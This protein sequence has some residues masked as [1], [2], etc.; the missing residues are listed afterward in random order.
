MNKAYKNRL[1]AQLA[2]IDANISKIHKAG[3]TA[4]FSGQAGS[5]SVTQGD[6]NTL[7][8]QRDQLEKKLY[9]GMRAYSAVSN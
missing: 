3:Q 1:E 2:E 8:R 7:I 5:Q 6:L 9:G 4:S